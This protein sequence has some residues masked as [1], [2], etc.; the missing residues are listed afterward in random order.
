MQLI[1]HQNLLWLSS[2]TI[3][4]IPHALTAAILAGNGCVFNFVNQHP[5]NHWR[6]TVESMNYVTRSEASLPH[7]KQHGGGGWLFLRFIDPA[8]TPLPPLTGCPAAP[9]KH[10][11]TTPIFYAKWVQR[12]PH[13]ISPNTNSSTDHHPGRV[14]GV[15]WRATVTW[16]NAITDLFYRIVMGRSASIVA[17]W[18]AKLYRQ[19]NA[20][21]ATIGHMFTRQTWSYSHVDCRILFQSLSYVA[22]GFWP[23]LFSDGHTLAFFERETCVSLLMNYCHLN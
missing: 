11:I 7:P 16:A 19:Q 4:L 20:V 10:C 22:L 15:N 6:S 14:T 23:V 21:Q 17:H 2:T 8:T 5:Q 1:H 18:P 3:S 9:Q 13:T 12:G